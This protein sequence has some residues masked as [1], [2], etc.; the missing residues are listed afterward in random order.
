MLNVLAKKVF[1][2]RN[3]RILKSMRPLVNRVNELEAKYKSMTDEELRAQTAQFKERISK[4]EPLQSLQPEAFAVVRE[5]A[6]RTLGMRHFDVQ[7]I[8]GAVLHNGMI[9]EMK[10]GEGKT[11]VAT[12]PAYLNA[13]LGK[14]VHIVTVNDY[15][16]R[17]DSEWMG[18]VYNFLGLSVG[19]VHAGLNEDVKRQAYN[20]DITYGQNNEFGFDYL[21]DN[22][23]FSMSETLQREHY[24]AIVDE[25]DSILIDEARTPLI[26]SGPAE[27][28]TD[29]Y[30]RINK[31]I[32][33]L[34]KDKHF[35]IE[36]RTK[37]PSLTEEGVAKVEQLLSVENLY[38]PNNIEL[39]H[40][41]QQA[42]KAHAVM[43]RD[44]DYVVRDG[45]V[46]IVD[47]FTGRLMP[48][49][50][51]S[52]GLHQAIEAK[53]G[54]TIARENRTL[55]S[56]T[57]QNFFRM[58]Q[59]LS[60]MTGTA[61]TEAVEF[62]H[63]Y[64]LDVVVIPTNKPMI[65][66]DESDQVYRSRNEKYEAVIDEI[67]AT[68]E[69]GQPIL[70]GTISIEQSETLSK[71]LK[72][73][74]IQHNVLN[75]KHHEKEAEIVAQAGRFS[76]VTI[77]TNMAG[78]GTDIVLGGN[79]EFMAA[80]EAKTKD[81]ADPDYQAALAKYSE[82][83]AEEKKRVLA[84]GGLFIIG[85]ERHESRRIDNQLRGRAGRQGDPG[86]SRFYVSLEDDL[87]MRF[88]GERIQ[89]LM[90]RLGW[91]EGIAI[92]GRLISRSIESAQ[93][94]VEAFHF[95][96]RKHVT[97]FDDV[98]NKQRQV[99]Y[100]LRN[101]VLAHHGV[102][103]E[104]LTMM[105]DLLEESVLSICNEET[106]PR[107][108]NIADLEGRFEFL[109]REKIKITK[110]ANQQEIFD[111]V[112]KGA[113]DLYAR[114]VAYLGE[115]LSSLATLS[116][117][118][119]MPVRIQISRSEDKPFDVST[120]EQDTILETLDHF[121]N[122]HLQM[123]DHLREGIGLRGYGQKNPL[124]EYQK[125]G[126]VLFQRMLDT[127]KESVVRKIYYYEVPDAKELLA[128]IEAEH[129]RREALE[130]QMRMIH[131]S[132]Q[133][134]A[135]AAPDGGEA[136]AASSSE[137]RAANRDPEEQRARMLALKKAR[138]KAGK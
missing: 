34:E 128:H 26:I 21:R 107:D 10:T 98:M 82:Q 19:V 117:D 74:N 95:D 30:Y 133:G 131:D 87:M 25:V 48:G 40:H 92:D 36:L 35:Q 65:R 1:G 70:V 56:I 80:A 103:E 52:D 113:R 69:T 15:L 50:R 24:F 41:T 44:V 47:E 4:G 78:R 75:A 6:R 102:R 83:C 118:D 137:A 106:K 16:A 114:R 55:A 115:R 132:P 81:R 85:T 20:S 49:R 39:L 9:A 130:R 96:S 17:R 119:A 12:L 109:F 93:K 27:D 116:T 46:I 37:Q 71:M 97:E 72:S 29:K 135:K 73:R 136:A 11:L 63:I 88:G 110:A 124:H 112:R 64:S 59:K 86:K 99:V 57:F 45:Q 105:D 122:I 127:V 67:V 3:D 61:D 22:M 14:G 53:E 28:P 23:K 79:A 62:K 134:L 13:L 90:K 108:W 8:G 5:G 84:A 18:R 76:S 58:Y 121:W 60:G 91:E 51:W 66:A 126:F 31:I 94:K 129:K 38:E 68:R 42:L 7:L 33:Y 120:I 43:E 77:S 101:R 54:V 123:M 89:V 32:P 100:N 125:E 111:Q 138:R 104:I 2:T